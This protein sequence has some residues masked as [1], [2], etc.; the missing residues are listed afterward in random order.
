MCTLTFY[1][2]YETYTCACAYRYCIF[3]CVYC[4]VF[5]T[6]TFLYHNRCTLLFPIYRLLK[7]CSIYHRRLGNCAR[8]ETLSEYT[9]RAV[10]PAD[11]S[12]VD[13]SERVLDMPAPFPALGPEVVG[14]RN[15]S[16]RDN[17]NWRCSR[18]PQVTSRHVT[19]A[20]HTTGYTLGIMDAGHSRRA[21]VHPAQQFTRGGVYLKCI[22]VHYRYIYTYCVYTYAY[23]C[24]VWCSVC[25][26]AY[27]RALRLNTHHGD[28]SCMSFV[29]QHVFLVA[30]D[31]DYTLLCYYIT[32]LV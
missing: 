26:T 1:I 15:H 17:S 3:I 11:Q 6:Y 4:T 19:S 28:M 30:H 10:H 2:L 25:F 21:A 5:T 9:I 20:L 24:N 29:V 32:M 8:L 18:R 27:S 13:C 12:D 14:E 31:F 7:M 16:R 22:Y 23:T